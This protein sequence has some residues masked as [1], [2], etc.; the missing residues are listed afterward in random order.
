MTVTAFSQ[1]VYTCNG[2]LTDV[3]SGG[4]KSSSTL[5]SIVTVKKVDAQREVKD[6]TNKRIRVV[7]ESNIKKYGR[8]IARR[9]FLYN[10]RK[11]LKKNSLYYKVFFLYFGF[12]GVRLVL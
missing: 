8:L 10:Y 3:N 2:I 6:F 11:I 12:F 4:K 9:A 5:T 7:C 1:A